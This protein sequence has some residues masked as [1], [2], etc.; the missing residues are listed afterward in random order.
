MSDFF[1]SLSDPDKA[2][3]YLIAQGTDEWDEIRR[4][5]F[6]SSEMH[7]LMGAAYRPMT[8]QELADR[9]KKGKGSSTTRI[10]VYGVL[11]D[12]AKTYVKQKVAEVFT[13]RTQQNSYAFPLVYGTDMEPEAADYFAKKTGFELEAVGFVPFGEHAGGSPDRYVGEDEILEIKCPY[14]QDTQVDYLLLTDQW[15]LKAYNEE[16]YW[17]CQSN[18]FFTQKR[19][20]HFVTYDPR[21]PEKHRMTHI[22]IKPDMQAYDAIAGKIEAAVKEK[23]E[24]IRLIEGN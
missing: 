20:C 6:T 23:L 10:E 16:Y 19:L 17:Q 1:S 22:Q 21:Y 3:Q 13:G 12:A 15:D 14:S 18:L 8:E 2:Q 11:S 4:G 7:R 9:P 5:R 24:L